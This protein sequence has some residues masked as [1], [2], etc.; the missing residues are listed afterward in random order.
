M[1]RAYGHTC[2]WL[3]VWVFK[4]LDPAGDGPQGGPE[5]LASSGTTTTCGFALLG[6]GCCRCWSTRTSR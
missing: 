1:H 4:T 5:L 3:V 2:S 6:V